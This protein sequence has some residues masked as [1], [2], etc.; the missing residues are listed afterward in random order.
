MKLAAR[1][2][3]ARRRAHLALATLA[4]AAITFVAAPSTAGAATAVTHWSQVAEQTISVG[5]GPASSEA[6]SGVVHAAV[7]DAVAATEGGLV[8]FVSS[9]TV[10]AGAST[11]AAVATAARDVLMARVPL[12]AANIQA[13]Y[14]LFMAAVPAGAAKT[15]GI[16]VGA[17]VAAAQLAA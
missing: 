12:Q 4:L 3:L 11:D 1:H 2:L 16:A 9:P 10:A 6:I 8:P 5:R 7:Y 13:A 14:D 15:A 17:E